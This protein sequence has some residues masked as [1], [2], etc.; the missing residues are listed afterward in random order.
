MK[1]RIQHI[2]IAKGIAIIA[3]VLGHSWIT[4]HNKG[5]LFNVLFSVHM[6]LFF[7]VSGVFLHNRGSFKA[8]FINKFDRIMKPYFITLCLVALYTW[9]FKGASLGNMLIG[10]FFASGDSIGATGLWYWIA[11]WF[12]PA[13]F[14]VSLLSFLINRYIKLEDSSA[15]TKITFLLLLGFF[16]S[17]DLNAFW[18]IK[19]S[20]FSE[21][22]IVYG[23]HF[24]MPGLPWCIDLALISSVFYLAGYWF[25]D[26]FLSRQFKLIATMGALAIFIAFH[27][28]WNHTVDLN[29][30]FYGSFLPTT[31]Q[32]FSGIYVVIQLSLLIERITPLSKLL[33]IIGQN[34]LYILLFHSVILNTLQNELNWQPLVESIFAVIIAI[35]VPVIIAVA[36][37][38]TI[39]LKY[40]YLPFPKRN[41]PAI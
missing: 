7:L 22:I 17:H 4:L 11:L 36:I 9:W 24:N 18:N 13:L 39:Y 14:I 3:V 8:F 1:Q 30:R 15:L 21:P 29:L 28:L 40:C 6:P 16:A 19:A 41:K 33:N 35:I 37:K 31:I 34:S 23:R 12:L 27:L 20:L 26:L 5:E 10:I 2:E 38:N 25:R 32:A